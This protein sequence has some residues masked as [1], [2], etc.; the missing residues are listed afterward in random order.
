M[1]DDK[2]RETNIKK[3]TY[4]YYDGTI[5]IIDFNLKNKNR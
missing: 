4:F 2:L 5:N 1:A 3:C